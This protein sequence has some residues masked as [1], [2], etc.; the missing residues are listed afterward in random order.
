M[1]CL[2]YLEKKRKAKDDKKRYFCK[3][4]RNTFVKT[5]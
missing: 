2:K 5:K 4:Q 3:Q 1:K